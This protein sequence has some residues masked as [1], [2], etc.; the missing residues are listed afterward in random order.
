MSKASEFPPFDVFDH[1]CQISLY[2][3]QP[4]GDFRHPR[5]Q[6]IEAGVQARPAGSSQGLVTVGQFA[7]VQHGVQVA[8]MPAKRRGQGLQRAGATSALDSVVLEF[9][10]G[11]LRDM[12]PLRKLPLAPAELLNTFVDGPG[13]RLPILRHATEISGSGISNRA[14]Q[15]R[16]LNHSQ[17]R[18]EI[19]EIEL[20]SAI[21]WSIFGH[22]S[23]AF[24]HESAALSRIESGVSRNA[25]RRE[26]R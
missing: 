11:G 3:V 17:C 21:H 26:S 20:K 13:Y 9:A 23:A 2:V 15:L 4:F 6:R 10:D 12:R 16:N 8:R 24:A 25:S 22:F 14:P 1:C 19:N 18:A 5:F 7:A